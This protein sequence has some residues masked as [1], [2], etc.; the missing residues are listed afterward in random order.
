MSVLWVLPLVV[1]AVGGFFLA[2]A[3][4]HAATEANG[5]AADAAAMG[6]LRDA[7][8]GLQRS[9]EGAIAD[10]RGADDV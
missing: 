6:D 10:P 2:R 4:Q 9:R 8:A 5:L 3:M 1:L 7:L